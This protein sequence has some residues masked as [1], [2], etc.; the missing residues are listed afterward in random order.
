MYTTKFFG[1]TRRFTLYLSSTIC[2]MGLVTCTANKDSAKITVQKAI[3]EGL[4]EQEAMA[5]KLE[6][7]EE[8]VMIKRPEEI[9]QEAMAKKREEQERKAMIKKLEE[10]EAVAREIEEQRQKAIA[11]RIEEEQKAIEE[12]I[13]N[14]PEPKFTSK[15]TYINIV[16]ER[17][18]WHQNPS[19]MAPKTRI[20]CSFELRG[21]DKEIPPTRSLLELMFGLA[22]NPSIT[23]GWK[24]LVLIEGPEE[25]DEQPKVYKKLGD[26]HISP[27]QGNIV[28][29]SIDP[30]MSRRK[31][32]HDTSYKGFTVKWGFLP[33]GKEWDA[34]PRE[35]KK[36]FLKYESPL[37]AFEKKKERKGKKRY[38]WRRM[39][40]PP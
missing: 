16:R 11:K 19:S 4:E 14:A 27:A 20:I 15:L 7:Q 10:Q 8:Q 17:S 31:F 30:R 33:P 1:E 26:L 22:K 29:V 12:K 32:L 3:V 24:L 36:R 5:R 25:W 18:S 9:E 21:T 39:A 37:G 40:T 2:L 28:T 13:K 6:E 38:T 35:E 34:L 23:K